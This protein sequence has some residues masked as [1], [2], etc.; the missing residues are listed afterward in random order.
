MSSCSVLASHSMVVMMS[1]I[2]I[3]VYSAVKSNDRMNVCLFW[4]SGGSL[5]C[6]RCV[7]MCSVDV[8]SM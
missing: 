5:S 6:S 4:V 1:S 8:V 2:V 7:M 3:L